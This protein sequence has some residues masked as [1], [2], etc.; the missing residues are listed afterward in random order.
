MKYPK[1]R[2]LIEAVKAIIRGPYTSAF[3]Y[4]PHKPFDAFRGRTEFHEKDC[5]GCAACAQVCPTGAISFKD[6]VE[7]PRPRR[8]LTIRW[9][10]CVFCGNCQLNCLTGKGIMLSTDFDLATVEKRDVLRQT[11]E[12]DLV[13]CECCG[14][15]I[16]PR[17][18]FTFAAEKLGPLVFSNASLML[19][20]LGRMSLAQMPSGPGP[21]K[22]KKE[23]KRQDRVRILCPKCRREAAAKS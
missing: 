3:P 9:D 15:I 8:V 22:D 10:I 11:I 23:I 13:L 21:A 7:G 19:F 18:Q 14:D 17:D 16:A 12:K 5:V 2:E 1:L 6:E 4:R 20:Y